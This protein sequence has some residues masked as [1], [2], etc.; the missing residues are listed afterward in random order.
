MKKLT[1]LAFIIAMPLFTQA[2][3]TTQGIDRDIFNICATIFTMGLF[4]IFILAVIK[5]ILDYRIRN[6]IVEK[7]IPENLASSLIQS[8]PKENRNSNIKWFA[9]LTGLGSGLIIIHYTEPVGIHSL[10]I[11]AFCMAAS[12]LGYYFFLQKTDK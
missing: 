8:N 7:G 1:N 12:F 2:Q 5:R 6:R 11:M 4:M 10:A 9:L 3:G